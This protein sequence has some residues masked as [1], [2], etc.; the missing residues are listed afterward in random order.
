MTLSIKEAS[1]QF[2]ETIIQIK[3]EVLDWL[4]ITTPICEAAA[5]MSAAEKLAV[6]AANS[7]SSEMEYHLGMSGAFARRKFRDECFA[8]NGKYYNAS[9]EELNNSRRRQMENVLKHLTLASTEASKAAKLMEI[10]LLKT[11]EAL[12]TEYSTLDVETTIKQAETR[13]KQAETRAREAEKRARDAE[14]RMK[15]AETRVMEVEAS[16]DAVV[17]A[18]KA[19]A[20]LLAN[21]VAERAHKTHEAAKVVVQVT[22]T[23]LAETIPQAV[24][25]TEQ[26]HDMKVVYNDMKVVYKKKPITTEKGG[27]WAE[28]KALRTALFTK[29]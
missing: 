22:E 8:R 2:N 14:T 16:A 19:S 7:A 6:G 11:Q 4:V 3:D 5:A 20:N 10:A 21:L 12:K 25:Q 1:A 26:V 15:Q 29:K 28:R 27:S 13:I 17:E 24:I 9:R 23:S 18:T